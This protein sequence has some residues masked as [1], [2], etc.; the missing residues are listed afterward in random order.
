MLNYDWNALT[1]AQLSMVSSENAGCVML[2]FRPLLFVRTPY[3][4][5]VCK[6]FLSPRCGLEQLGIRQRG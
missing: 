6:L 1:S 3:S 2:S 4:A 5:A